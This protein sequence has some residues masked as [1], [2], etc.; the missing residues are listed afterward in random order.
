V[1][2]IDDDAAGFYRAHNTE[3]TPNEPHRLILKLSTVAKAL[4]LPA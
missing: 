3:Q 4:R 2:T 1:D